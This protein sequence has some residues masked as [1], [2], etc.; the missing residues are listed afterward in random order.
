MAQWLPVLS[1][2]RTLWPLQVLHTPG[3]QAYIQALTQTL[4][5]SNSMKAVLYGSVPLHHCH[6]TLLSSCYLGWKGFTFLIIHNQCLVATVT[7]DEV[8]EPLGSKYAGAPQQAKESNYDKTERV[9]Q[10]QLC[11]RLSRGQAPFASTQ[12]LPDRV[13]FH[14]NHLRTAWLNMWGTQTD[15]N[16]FIEFTAWHLLAKNMLLF[17]GL[18]SALINLSHAQAPRYL[19]TPVTMVTANICSPLDRVPLWISLFT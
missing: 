1:T 4:K 11:R 8:S 3:G 6:A 9:V 15:A 12:P 19:C 14:L 17:L 16:T 5:T 10:A 2:L 18:S 7:W 13:Q